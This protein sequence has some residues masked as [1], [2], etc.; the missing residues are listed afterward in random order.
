MIKLSLGL[1]E[2]ESGFPIADIAASLPI[3]RG[4]KSGEEGGQ[5]VVTVSGPAS[6]KSSSLLDRGTGSDNVG[7]AEQGTGQEEG[8]GGGETQCGEEEDSP[9]HQ[10]DNKSVRSIRSFE[11]MTSE[12]SGKGRKS[13]KMPLS[14]LANGRQNSTAGGSI[15]RKS[16]TDR[17]AHM[18]TLAGVKVG[19]LTLN[20]IK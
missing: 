4:L 17:L 9:V 20:S 10:I 14:M 2:L 3:N 11:S 15:G 7:V 16:L 6:A 8:G 5:Q 1:L 18:S 13:S 19:R 12:T